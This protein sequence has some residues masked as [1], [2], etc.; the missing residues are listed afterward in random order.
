MKLTLPS[1]TCYEIVDQ[2]VGQSSWICNA[3]NTVTRFQYAKGLGLLGHNRADWLAL[4]VGDC[5]KVDEREY[6]V[7]EMHVLRAMDLQHYEENGNVLDLDAVYERFYSDPNG[8]T[9]QT[10]IGNDGRLFVRAA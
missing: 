7:R 4:A 1:G 10:C 8:L 5:L 2:P 3:P 9:L 6:T